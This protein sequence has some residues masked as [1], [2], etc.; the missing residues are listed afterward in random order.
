MS[1]PVELGRDEAREL[2]QRE[3]AD[4]RYDAEPPLGQ[5]II[6]WLIE[7]L[8]RLID[9]AAGALTSPVGAI[10]LAAVIAV[11]A[12][13]VLR[14]SPLARRA[15]SRDARLFDDGRRL[16]RDHRAAA[17]A[18]ARD[19]QWSAAV[20]ER[21]R[22]IVATLEERSVLDERPGRTADEAARDAG[23]AVPG[24]A[25]D[26]LAAAQLFDVVHYGGGDATADDDRR[27]RELDEAVGGSRGRPLAVL[28]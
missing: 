25:T 2:A 10:V 15:A 16:A 6:E 3:L 24:L 20:V 23:A 4:P 7:Q 11:I 12:A 5:R 17:E 28:P 8:N 14:Y 13:I 18:A 22:A 19:Q 26:L 9:G 21:F 1:V 27:M